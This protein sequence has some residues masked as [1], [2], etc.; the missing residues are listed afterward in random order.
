MNL[1]VNGIVVMAI[2]K[3]AIKV[4]TKFPKFKAVGFI[5]NLID[6]IAVVNKTTEIQ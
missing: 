4:T 3:D 6:K 2:K 1:I 5:I